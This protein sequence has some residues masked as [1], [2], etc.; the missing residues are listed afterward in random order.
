MRVAHVNAVTGAGS[1]GRMVAE[2]QATLPEFGVDSLA[3]VS[4][5]SAGASEAYVVNSR[6]DQAS[7]ALWS[8]LDGR[9]GLHSKR[10]TVRLTEFLERAAPD[11]VHLHNLH[12]N[13]VHLP[14]LLTFLARH[15]VATVLTLHDAWGYTGKCTHYTVAGCSKWLHGC[16]GCPQLRADNPSWFLDRTAQLWRLKRELYAAIPRLA[17]VGVSDWITA[18]ARR[19][20]L[21]GA[22]S[23]TR[24]YNWVDLSVFSAQAPPGT[25]GEPPPRGRVEAGAPPVRTVLSVATNWS[26]TKGLPALAALADALA[27]EARI[28]LVGD[29]PQRTVLPGNVE[30]VG[31]VGSPHRLAELYRRACVLANFS[32]EESFGLVAAE[33]IA[34]GTPVVC[35]DSTANPELVAG[36]CG[37][38]VPAGDVGGMIT[39]VRRVLR[40]GPDHYRDR[41]TRTAR[42]RFARHDR[43]GDYANL[44]RW[45][46][47]RRD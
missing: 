22:S 16:G 40:D 29:V 24:I 44:Y 39:A 8:R 33:S 19:S 18:E 17:V 21:A 34:C 12:N 6:L 20:I 31:H 28:L 36:G 9:Q 4:A 25:P 41:C 43:I 2:L 7:H 10:A 46:S 3:C 38:A 47:G 23:I 42:E 30:R 37:I 14:V 35:F 11:V 27:D 5:S 13:F 1:T 15:D 32:L 26:D 45:L